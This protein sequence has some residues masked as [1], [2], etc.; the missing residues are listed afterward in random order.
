MKRPAKKSVTVLVGL[1]VLLV[2]AG[3]AFTYWTNSGT[4]AGEAETGTNAAIVVNQTSSVS[5]MAPGVAPQ[6]LSGNFDNDNTG[7]VY[8]AGVTATGTD[9]TGCPASD[10]TIA[11]TATVADPMS[12][13]IA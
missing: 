10:Y 9:Q 3:V 12:E 13:A 8:V 2:G 7:P 1:V 11:G 5:A 6:A 4:G